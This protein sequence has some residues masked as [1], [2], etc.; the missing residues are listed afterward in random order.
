MFVLI[1]HRLVCDTQAD[2][3]LVDEVGDPTALRDTVLEDHSFALDR[4]VATHAALL[5]AAF[6]VNMNRFD[7][8]SVGDAESAVPNAPGERSQHSSSASIVPP[9]SRAGSLIER[10]RV[11]PLQL[12][13]HSGS[14]EARAQLPSYSS[15]TSSAHSGTKDTAS[16][17]G[18]KLSDGPVSVS[19]RSQP[20]PPASESPEPRFSPT[21]LDAA[22]EAAVHTAPEPQ[23]RP[24][25]VDM[26]IVPVPVHPTPSDVVAPAALSSE[27]PVASRAAPAVDDAIPTPPTATAAAAADV[28]V[29]SVPASPSIPS[30][31]GS[32][33]S[34]SDTPAGLARPGSAKSISVRE[35]AGSLSRPGSAKSVSARDAPA[36]AA[37]AAGALSRP[38]SAKS[39]SA[40]D[41]P[42]KLARTGSARSIS[43]PGS[44]VRSG[45]ARSIASGRAEAAAPAAAVVAEIETAPAALQG[46]AVPQTV[47]AA[48]AVKPAPARPAPP[49]PVSAE[50]EPALAAS[51]RD[52]TAGDRV[53]QI[54]AAE[55]EYHHVRKERHSVKDLLLKWEK[56]F[57]AREGRPAG[58]ADKHADT[59]IRDLYYKCAASVLCFSYWVA[60]RLSGRWSSRS[61]WTRPRQI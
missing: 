37:A 54:A 51:G 26:L 44:P 45:S 31:P 42:G 12:R 28:E 33:K 29:A 22:E 61:S 24:A 32:A 5:R 39:V 17:L 34:I 15:T 47:A 58:R 25:A 19:P 21:V 11:P 59:A 4:R 1:S 18:R 55:L 3:S 2:F 48:E 6:S 43:S 46:V 14:N 9:L 36:A 50:R 10:P 38:G 27:E 7:S 52:E 20:L 16:A 40:R 53:A 57:E 35:T 30:R 23:Q 56:A 49:V 60:D 41:A 8:A 13:S